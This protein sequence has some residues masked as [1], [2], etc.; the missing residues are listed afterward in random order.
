M[1][2]LQGP[3]VDA[4]G[5]TADG[6]AFRDIDDY[7][8]LLLSDRDALARALAV[9]V[10]AYATGAAPGPLDGPEIEAI[11]AAAR[12]KDYGFRTL[13]HAVVAGRLFRTK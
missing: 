9:K 7:K 4:S 5:V 2:Y 8:A 6:R 10:L 1:P 13:V 12:A 11:V 3:P